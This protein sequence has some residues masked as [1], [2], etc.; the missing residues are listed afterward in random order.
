M[1]S[2]QR[3]DRECDRPSSLESSWF[4]CF[5]QFLLIALS[6]FYPLGPGTSKPPSW[7]VYHPQTSVNQPPGLESQMTVSENWNRGM[8][9]RTTE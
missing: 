4:V 6:L 3:S 5:F 8:R 2:S 9:Q 1:E 7:L